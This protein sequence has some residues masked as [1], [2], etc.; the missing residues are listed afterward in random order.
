MGLHTIRIAPDIVD[1]DV[2]KLTDG[3]FASGD[4]LFDWQELKLP[5]GAN[6]LVSI[7][8]Y[9]MGSDGGVQ[10][11]TDIHFIFA[12]TIDRTVPGTLGE[13]NAAQT[14]CFE[15]PLHY[16]GG[17]KVEGTS[18]PTL[19]PAFG[20]YFTTGFTGNNGFATSM[21]LEGETPKEGGYTSIYVAAFVQAAIN[22]ETN[23]L[24]TEQVTTSAS[25]IPVDTV[26]PRKCF[27][28]GDT[29]Y[30][31][32]DDTALGTVKSL[33]SDTITLNSTLGAQVENNEEMIN[34]TPVKVIF[35]F[36]S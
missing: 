29:V 9:I 12:K 17:V 6:K 26:D 21:V 1:G 2:S 36:E 20:D 34:A 10:T 28:V 31:H 14:A 27:V 4:I 3:N 13:E 15:L 25:A 19:G 5:Y 32:T 18:Y 30:T 23:C 35:G 16:I 11:N 33:A 8:G 24:A 22:L 7:S